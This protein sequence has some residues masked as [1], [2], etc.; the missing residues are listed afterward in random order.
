VIIG[1]LKERKRDERRVALRP[2]HVGTLIT[3]G[4]HLLVESEAGALAGFPDDEYLKT[5]AVITGRDDIYRKCELLVKVKRP[6]EDEVRLLRRGQLLFT[7]LHFD[8]NIPAA[9]IRQI[10]DTGCTGIAFEWVE[11]NGTFPVLRPMSE[12]TGGILALKAMNL[13]LGSVG[14]IGGAAAPKLKRPCAMIIGLGHIGAN[15]LNMLLHCGFDINLVDKSPETVYERATQYIDEDFWNRS[16]PCVNVIRLDE[17]EPT[18]ALDR[19]RAELPRTNILICAAVRRPSFP[20][21]K[22]EF[23]VDRRGVASMPAGSIVCDGT[24]MERDFIE[25]CV[26][27]EALDETYVEEGKIHYNCDH[28]PSASAHSASDSLSTEL[29]PYVVDLARGFDEAILRSPALYGAVMC[30]NGHITHRY[31]SEK[32][33]FPWMPLSALLEQHVGTMS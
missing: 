19:I 3:R 10:V 15:A 1:L 31:S 29:L 27:T 2:D 16:K 21:S 8:E 33:G 26:S 28:I 6:L 11:E 13:L 32:K 4:H 23:L 14:L 25:T 22:C 9:D 17:N 30:H 24:A 20:K 12:I 5:A 7:F 18:A